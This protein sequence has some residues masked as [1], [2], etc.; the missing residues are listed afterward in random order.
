LTEEGFSAIVLVEKEIYDYL[1]KEKKNGR[2]PDEIELLHA[3]IPENLNKA[4]FAARVIAADE[5]TPKNNNP[6]A[7]FLFSLHLC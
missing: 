6:S 7:S 1:I 2:V 3:P 5:V 4:L